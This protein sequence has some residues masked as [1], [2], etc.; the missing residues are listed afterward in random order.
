MSVILIVEDGS[1]VPNANSYDSC[2]NAI[3]YALN[4]GVTLPADV[5]CNGQVASWLILGTDFLESFYDRY[6]GRP[7]SYTQALSWPRQCVD[8]DPDNPFPDDEIPPQLIEALDQC[9]IAQSQGIVLQPLTDHSQGGYV[10]ED[11]LGPIITK[12]SEKIGTTTN[13]LLPTVM[14]LLNQILVPTAALRT[15]RI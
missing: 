15:V 4:R 14:A 6:P 10:T 3:Q 11:K 12:Y 13:P 9:V 5:S 1:G 2:V 8:F 7:T